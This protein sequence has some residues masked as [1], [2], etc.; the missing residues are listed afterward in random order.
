MAL[1]SNIP[2]HQKLI[3]MMRVEAGSL[4]PQGQS[5]LQGFCEFAQK[6]S[7]TN[8]SSGHLWQFLPRTDK[9]TPEISFKI[10][11]KHISKAQAEKYLSK[12][13][14]ELEPFTW[15]AADK[16]AAMIEQYFQR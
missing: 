3:V 12:F 6:E 1:P 8:P 10:G 14:L 9:S 4:G 5:H 7:E 2:D 16:V 15:D 11:D 13:G